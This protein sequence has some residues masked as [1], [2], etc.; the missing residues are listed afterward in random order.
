MLMLKKN[1]FFSIYPA[2]A[3]VSQGQTALG[4]IIAPP[5]EKC[6]Y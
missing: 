6:G 2:I 4:A 5:G 1:S 3:K